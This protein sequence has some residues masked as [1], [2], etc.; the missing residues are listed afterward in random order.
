M[1]EVLSESL[2]RPVTA[3]EIGL[4]PLQ[5]ARLPPGAT[6]PRDPTTAL[7]GIIDHWSTVDRRDLLFTTTTFAASAFAAPVT[8]WL[9][10]SADSATPRSDG[11]RIGREDVATLWKA[12]ALAR[13][14]DSRY[15]G[16]DW[17]TGSVARCLRLQAAPMLR[18]S[19]TDEVGRN[20]Y[21]AAAELSRAVGWAAVDMSDH[22]SAQRHLT[23]ALRLARLA[24]DVQSGCHVLTTMA[25]QTL[26]AG[27]PGEAADMAEG[28][29]ERAR[30]AAAP[31]VL[32]FAKLVEAR[33]HART[34]QT[35]DAGAALHLAETLLGQVRADGDPEYLAYFTHARLAADAVE[36][37]R[38]L[39]QPAAALRWNREAG[40]MSQQHFTRSVGLR[41]SI[42]AAAHLQAG[43]LEQGLALGHR[44]L[45]ILS[46]V[47]SNRARDYVHTLL[48]TAT[49]W[50]RHPAVGELAIRA[51]REIGVPIPA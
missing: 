28:A 45:D 33:A 38:D 23:N 1:A 22:R 19:Y 18:G 42:V 8:R 37:H 10:V 51:H 13:R 6:F 24:G 34:G 48:A 31:R 30:P 17:R 3:G 16:G 41:A 39:M 14:Q 11:R 2:G 29:Y 32:A 46:T 26:L 27:H 44:S 5:E 49:R 4:A 7:R 43:D 20:L 15:G 40:T 36:I 35:R 50:K 47:Q 9:A 25:L 21:S 12:A